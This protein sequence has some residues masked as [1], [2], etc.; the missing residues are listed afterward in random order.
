MFFRRA[1]ARRTACNLLSEFGT[2]AGQLEGHRWTGTR[3]L[4]VVD[5]AG[6]VVATMSLGPINT[7]IYSPF[8]VKG[9]NIYLVVLDEDDVPFVARLRITR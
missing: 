4:D 2:G 6:R 7:S 9:D 1:D 8:T 3:E 5:A